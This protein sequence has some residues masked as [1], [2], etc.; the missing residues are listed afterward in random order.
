[1]YVLKKKKKSRSG[2]NFSISSSLFCNVRDNHPSKSTALK[3][4]NH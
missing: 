2:T 3:P 1:M 4:A